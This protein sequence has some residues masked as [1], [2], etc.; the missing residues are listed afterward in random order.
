LIAFPLKIL[1]MFLALLS[2]STFGFKAFG[3]YRPN[4]I[5]GPDP[6]G[7]RAITSDDTS[8]LRPVWSWVDKSSDPSTVY[9]TMSDD[10]I[11]GPF[12]IGFTFPYYWYSVSTFYIHSNGA[13]SFRPNG[14]FWTPHSNYIPNPSLPN[15]LIVGLGADLNPN[16]GGRIYYWTDGVDSL[17]VTFDSVPT[18]RQGTDCEGA[19]TFQII[20]TADGNITFNYGPQVGGYD[21][22]IGMVNISIGIESA[23]GNPGLSIHEDGSPASTNP[24]NN[25]AIKIFRPD[26]TTFRIADASA[27]SIFT[28]KTNHILNSGIFIAYNRETSF[29]PDV[30]VENVGTDTLYNTWAKLVIRRKYSSTIVYSDSVLI[31]VIPPGTVVS[32]NLRTINFSTFARDFYTAILTV[33]NSSDVNPLNNTQNVEIRLYHW[34]NPDTLYW[35]NW[36]ILT[37]GNILFTRWLGSG[38]GWAQRFDPRHYPFRI[39]SVWLVVAGCQSTN[40]AC[41]GPLNTP[42]FIARDT[43]GTVGR[44]L[45]A[46]TLAVSR[47]SAKIYT[48]RPTS[49]IIVSFPFFVGYIQVDSLGPLVGMDT[50]KPYSRQTFESTDGINWAPYRES[51][52]SDFVFV[53]WGRSLESTDISEGKN[54]PFNL[55]ITEKEVIL[56]YVMRVRIYTPVGRLIFDGFVDRVSF[57]NYP[58]GIYFVKVGDRVIKFINK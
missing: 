28:D 6:Y 53:V 58:K 18:W 57:E 31:P 4:D 22:G 2:A 30:K 10:D 7:Y 42:M 17:V 50:S 39:D 29:V 51:E 54:L 25:F 21:Y 38:G 34:T 32:Q 44:W 27:H 37:T 15:D 8:S 35:F 56:P 24:R 16:C 9:L 43:N 3:G 41:T 46:E 36:N 45:Y 33:R 13:I 40:P 12:S 11:K 23:I 20:L 1:P 49:P 14:G 55:R 26:T 52:A 5:F 48:L 19:H 47:D